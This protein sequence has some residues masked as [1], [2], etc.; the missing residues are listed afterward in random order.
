MVIA[1]IKDEKD[2]IVAFDVEKFQPGC[3]LIQAMYGASGSIANL[4]DT[5]KWLLSPTPKMRPYK[6]TGKELKQLVELVNKN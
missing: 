3:V 1:D 4:F 5:D 2:Y 6:I